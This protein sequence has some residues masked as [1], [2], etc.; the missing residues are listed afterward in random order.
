M[1]FLFPLEQ[2]MIVS[3][4]NQHNDTY[5]LAFNIHD[6]S[7]DQNVANADESD[8]VHIKV[9]PQLCVDLT[10]YYHLS[11]LFEMGEL[12]S[13]EI[14]VEVGRLHNAFSSDSAVETV[15]PLTFIPN[16]FY[17]FNSTSFYCMPFIS[18]PYFLFVASFL[19]L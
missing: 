16:Y 12:A 9:I 17:P 19:N 8:M 15:V 18:N 6:I 5:S 3:Y 14:I 11:I 7:Q 1:S 4:H 2:I 13:L 10:L